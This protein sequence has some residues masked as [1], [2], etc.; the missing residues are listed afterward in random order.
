MEGS[1]EA[2]LSE[3]TTARPGPAPDAAGDRRGESPPDTEPGEETGGSADDTLRGRLLRVLP[4]AG[5]VLGLG[6]VLLVGA[7]I[8]LY[9]LLPSGASPGPERPAAVAQP[10]AE[11]TGE[12]Y[13]V[14][15]PFLPSL[16]YE[17]DEGWPYGYGISQDFHRVSR[18]DDSALDFINVGQVYD[19]EDPDMMSVAAPEGVEGMAGWFR[20]HPR[21]AAGEPEETE[22]GGARGLEFDVAVSSGVEDYAA[23]GCQTSC[24]PLFRTSTGSSFSLESGRSRVI[25]LDVGGETVAVVVDGGTVGFEEFLAEAK[26]VL[27]SVEWGGPPGETYATE[28]FSPSL[29]LRAG[30]D[31]PYRYGIAIG[32]YQIWHTDGTLLS[33][34]N[35]REVYDPEN[36]V[37]TQPAPEDMAGWFGE[38]PHLEAGEP[39]PVEVGGAS[40][41]AFDVT[42]APLPKGYA[43]DTCDT[44]CVPLFPQGDG[45]AF[46]FLQGDKD[47]V[48]VLD[49]A[50]ETVVVTVEGPQDAFG[51]FMPRAEGVLDTV[52]WER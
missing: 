37:L 8:P 30:E 11:R 2:E 20:D 5:G 22:V 25:L 1:R 13:P 24:V 17:V 49:V 50:G 46:V 34:L 19:P 10:P 47:R 45:E 38:H 23:V 32:L 12:A 31:W 28:Q 42:V 33:F 26:E 9:S 7:V 39:E 44:P 48:V 36:P 14:T 4:V 15:E 16:S 3:E 27:G 52:R 41:V 18:E 6:I 35:V 51:D 21:L 43:A 29:S 40:G